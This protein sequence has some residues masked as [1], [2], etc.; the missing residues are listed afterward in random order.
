MDLFLIIACGSL[1]LFEIVELSRAVLT[2]RMGF[3]QNALTRSG[4][5]DEFWP[6]AVLTACSIPLFSWLLQRLIEGDP[7]GPGELN[8]TELVSVAML[9]FL[10][11][12]FL[13]RGTA[14]AGGTPFSRKEEPTQYWIIIALTVAAL[15]VL[16]WIALRLPLLS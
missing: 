4:D 1:V 8:P 14:S 13:L 15:A 5:P 6:N 10:L 11:V 2:G 7:P 9:A 16:T 3:G 12:R